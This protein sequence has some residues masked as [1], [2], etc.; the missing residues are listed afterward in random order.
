[1]IAVGHVRL[2]DKTEVL[3]RLQL[4]EQVV[5]FAGRVA[6]AAVSVDA[7]GLD[8]RAVVS[9]WLVS[10]H[11]FCCRGVVAIDIRVLD[12]GIGCMMENDPLVEDGVD[13]GICVVVVERGEVEMVRWFGQ[14]RAYGYD[15]LVEE[16]SEGRHICGVGG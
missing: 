13:Q 10:C 15:E 14:V 7:E 9:R 5:D 3:K 8:N 1:M 6:V 2:G 16:G 4:L 11:S 12:N